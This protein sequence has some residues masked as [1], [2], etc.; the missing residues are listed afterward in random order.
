[1][2]APS[3][4][5]NKPGAPKIL[6]VVP[7]FPKEINPWV[8]AHIEGMLRHGWQV[9]VAAKQIDRDGLPAFQAKYPQVQTF[10]ITVESDRLFASTGWRRKLQLTKAFGLRY[11]RLFPSGNVK[12]MQMRAG[13]VMEI[14]KRFRPHVMHAHFGDAGLVAAPVARRLGIP[15]SISF[16]GTDLLDHE[17]LKYNP[18]KATTTAATSVVYSSFMQRVARERLDGRIVRLSFGVQPELFCPQTPR[19]DWSNPVNITFVARLIYYKGQE[20]AIRAMVE[21][22]KRETTRKFRLT[23]VGDGPDRE[24]L[25][26]LVLDLEAPVCFAGMVSQPEVAS[27]VHAS[28]LCLVCS[29]VADDGWEE[30]FSY[31]ALEAMACGKPVI[32]TDTGALSETVG[33]GGAIVAPGDY[34]ALAD[35]IERM[36]Q[37]GSPASWAELARKRAEDFSLER[38]QAEHAAL[39]NEL[40]ASAR[41]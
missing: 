4:E 10:D 39:A 36:V 11:R 20:T 29:L 6:F 17:V 30:T 25:Q 33:G 19:A 8:R 3:G 18:Y 1:M 21:L 31:S 37:A 32:A 41:N 22:A 13:A 2:T 28:D 40:R 24:K 14:A 7:S 26:S 34:V 5:V 35:E 27:Y 16:H 9:V 15:L 38:M 12:R 23:L